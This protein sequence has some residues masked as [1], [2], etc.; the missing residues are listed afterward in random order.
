MARRRP[1]L[2]DPT[3]V[4]PV[5]LRTRL[6]P[7]WGD[8]EAVRARFPEHCAADVPPIR[9]HFLYMEVLDSWA[10]ANGFESERWA[11]FPDWH[12]LKAAGWCG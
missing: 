4:V 10:I 9:E 7:I 3:G 12:R 2:P 11:G 5:E 6:H 1:P 8:V